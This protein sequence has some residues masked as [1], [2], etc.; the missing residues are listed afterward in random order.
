MSLT[1]SRK[2]FL[3]YL[4]MALLTVLASAFALFNLQKLSAGAYNITNHHFVLM[5]NSKQLMDILLA[6]E[7]AEKKYLILRDPEL[8]QI[9]WKR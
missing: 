8:E 3:G 5:E 9:F 1:I 2:L 6:Q 7:S 4:F